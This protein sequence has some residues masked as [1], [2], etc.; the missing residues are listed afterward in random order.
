MKR[1]CRNFDHKNHLHKILYTPRG[2]ALSLVGAAV[3]VTVTRERLM[4]PDLVFRIVWK[5]SSALDASYIAE[6]LR[7]PMLRRQIESVATG[8][9]P[10]MKK[11]TKPAVLNLRFPLPPLSEQRRIVAQLDVLR[12]EARSSQAEAEKIRFAA[13]SSFEQALFGTQ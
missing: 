1:G 5:E 11:V 9:S 6:V 3:H 4:L 12:Q 7:M 8:T 13:K 2:N 10:S